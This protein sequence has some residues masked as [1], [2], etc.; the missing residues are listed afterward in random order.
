MQASLSSRLH[1]FGTN[2]EVLLGDRVEYRSFFLRRRYLG[3]VVCI[4]EMTGRERA[5]LRKNPE[6]WL[7]KLDSG[8]VTGWLY[9]PED[10]QPPARLR[11]VARTTSE[12]E[13]LSNAELEVEE[14]RL[15]SH[16][17]WL[18]LATGP[19]I[20]LVVLLLIAAIW[21]LARIGI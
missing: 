18:E 16:A 9:S 19:L 3:R 13:L 21:V 8:V 12:P 7:I 20:L 10:L 11:F 4:P 2:T 17:S 15:E 14:A 6:D 1:Y 5:Q